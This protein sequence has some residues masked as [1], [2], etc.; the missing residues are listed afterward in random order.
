MLYS[1]ISGKHCSNHVTSKSTANTASDFAGI[2][3]I[4]AGKRLTLTIAR[5]FS[6]F[7]D[8]RLFLSHYMV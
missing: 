1:N 6:G 4:S 8:Y 3:I 2:G 7:T 5:I